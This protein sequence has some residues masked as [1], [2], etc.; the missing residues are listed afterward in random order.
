MVSTKILIKSHL[1]EY[2]KGK[3]NDCNDTVVSFPSNS[4]IY[5]M[6]FDLMSKRPADR[7]TDSGNLEIN[8]PN[9]RE[10]KNPA[11]FNYMS[12]RAVAIFERKVETLFWADLHEFVDH[13]R[14]TYGEEIMNSTFIFMNKY[15]IES[16]SVDALL[17]NYQRW[18]D[19]VRKKSKKRAYKKC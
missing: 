14:T 19:R 2:I 1:A 12:N 4:D 13:Q 7:Q 8:L 11:Y 6:I 17:K 10:G 3:Y 15:N 18:K 9:R 16:I 5:V